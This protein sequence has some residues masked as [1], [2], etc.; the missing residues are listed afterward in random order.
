MASTEKLKNFLEQF[1]PLPERDWEYFQAKLERRIFTKKQ[2]ILSAGE[3][4]QYVSFI[5][6]GII[7]Y[8]VEDGD[9]EVSFEI[10]F[11]SGF[12]SAYDSF[13]TRA[14]APYHGEALTDVELWSI[15]HSH[16]QEIYARIPAGDRIGRLAAEQMYVWKNR[17]QH[18]LLTD[19][20]EQR[21]RDL[22]TDHRRII[23]HV[24]LKYLASYIGVTP[25]AL[26]RIRRRL[27]AGE[28]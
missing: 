9:K 23:Q 21:Y 24:P 10:A 22:L 20:A 27:S 25:Q 6:K 14:P 4:E 17:R 12:T 7:R 16:L 15:S 3:V 2:R 5:D 8:F 19:S 18:S 1:C 11:P 28:G 13:L 26:S